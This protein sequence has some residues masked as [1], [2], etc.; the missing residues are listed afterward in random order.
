[1]GGFRYLGAVIIAASSAS[2][3][4]LGAPVTLENPLGCEV[5]RNQGRRPGS[6]WPEVRALI[7]AN[8]RF[9]PPNLDPAFLGAWIE[10]ESDGRHGLATTSLGEVGYFQLHPAE[11]EDMAGIQNVARVINEIQT[12]KTANVRWGG[13]LLQHYDEA[14]MKFEIPRGTRLHHAL[15]KVMHSSRPRGIRWLQHVTAVLGRAPRDYNEFLVVARRLFDKQ[16]PPRIE[17][18][19]PSRLPSCAPSYLLERRDTY[20]MPGDHVAF[21]GDVPPFVPFALRSTV[22][23]MAAQAQALQAIALP[24]LGAAPFPGVEF[25]SPMPLVKVASGWWQP[26]PGRNGRHEGFDLYA[27]VGT[28]VLSTEDG[29]VSRWEGEYAGRALHVAHAGGWTSRYMH[30]DQRVEDGRRVN[31]GDVIATVGTTGLRSSAPHLHFAL[32]LQ[33]QLL[34]LYVQRFGM[35]KTGFGRKHGPG[36]AVP[37]EPLVPVAGY[38]QDVIDDAKRNGVPLFAPVRKPVAGKVFVAVGAAALVGMIGLS[39]YRRA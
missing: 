6:W 35:P 26:R 36:V 39:Y 18:S 16:I 11:I 34:P 15:L 12:S 10:H 14:V 37:A 30:L 5:G 17:K 29:I 3:T 23:A 38:Q 21:P 9:F 7:D 22:T 33:E 31:K 19:I 13:A 24:G 25:M 1:M 27:P 20:L 2:H 8:E 32:L 4:A 28:P